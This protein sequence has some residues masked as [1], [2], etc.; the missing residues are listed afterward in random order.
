MK[1]DRRYDIVR[2]YRDPNKGS[3]V[4]KKR[5]TLEQAQAH[6]KDPSTSTGIYF[7]GYRER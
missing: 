1:E 3:R 4:V 7:D 5:V 6:C 2:F